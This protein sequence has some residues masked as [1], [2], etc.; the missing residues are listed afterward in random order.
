MKF[1]TVGDSHS[2]IPWSSVVVPGIEIVT[3]HLGSKTMY[4]FGR[5]RLFC[6]D[7]KRLGIAEGEDVCFCFGEIDCRVHVHLHPGA[8]ARTVAR[9]FEAIEMNI[10]RYWPRDVFLMAVVPPRRVPRAIHYG[11]DY[12][13]LAYTH[14]VN[15]MLEEG[16]RDR[17]FRFIDVGPWCRDDKGFMRDEVADKR[18]HLAD[19][20][21][22]EMYLANLRR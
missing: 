15:D 7:F 12:D 3:H 4:G 2:L 17:G 18:T 1:H 22:L 16:C 8:T 20:K 19:P 13:R 14:V 5:D 10:V 6:C 11:S 21:P 9:Y